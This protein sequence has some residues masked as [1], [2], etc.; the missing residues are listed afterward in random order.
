MLQTGTAAASAAWVQSFIVF[1]I[2]GQLALLLPVLGPLRLLVRMAV[3]GVSLLFLALLPGRGTWHPSARPA[4]CVLAILGLSLFH[5]HT[6]TVLAGTAQAALYLSILAP[7][8]WVPRARIDL[9]ALRRIL[10][11]LWAF[12]T[13][14]AGFGILQVHF[15]G[16]FQPNLSAM[17]AGQGEGYVSQLHMTT[18]SGQRVLRP[19]GLTDTPGGAAIAGFYAV[20]LG[21]G[22][23]LT[24]RRGWLK[25][26][27]LGSMV[28]GMAS[29]YLAQV[30]SV[31]LMLAFCL[32]AFC[33]MLAWRGERR[34]LTLVAGLIATVVLLS[35]S[36]AVSVGG[37]S[38][39]QRWATLVEDRPG[40]VYYRNRGLLLEQTVEEL[41]P[42]YPLGAGLG[43]WG[44]MNLYFGDNSDPERAC[45]WAELQWTGWILDGGAPLLLA[46]VAAL[47]LACRTALQIAF[48]RNAG[49]LWI[50][51]G[52]LLAYNL[53]AFAVTF[54][55]SFFVGQ[56]GLEFWLLNAV[57][58][59]ATQTRSQGSGI[60]SQGSGV[61]CQKSA[62]RGTDS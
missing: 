21:L 12:H 40:K 29:L 39:T 56:G 26:I 48:L 57:L 23:V 54:S 31:L 28:L 43:R 32:F 58:F 13:V 7:L 24:E 42:K 52:V 17:I 59:A 5:P 14:S 11:V 3:F 38:V 20:L 41:L 62:V 61:R 19:M 10:L 35:F 55:Y 46:Y 18:A 27:C 6:N 22:F 4:L 30:R 37:A 53:G 1:L 50:W 34:R 60:R 47:A 15:P 25:F 51:G 33:G 8:F 49:T 45:L 2:V 9:A 16:R 44:M 36:W